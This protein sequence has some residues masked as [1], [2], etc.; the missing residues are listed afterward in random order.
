[1]TKINSAG[2]RLAIVLAFALA[3]ACKGSD[4][5]Q[6][7]AGTNGQDGAAGAPGQN[8]TD[9]TSGTNGT[10]GTNAVNGAVTTGMVIA[11]TGATVNADNTVAVTFTVKDDQGFPVDLKGRYSLNTTIS[12]RFA[13]GYVTKDAAGNVLPYTV[14][15]KSSGSPTALTA[16][17]VGAAATAAGQI[18]ENGTGAGS[19]TYTFP[20]SAAITTPTASHTLWIQASRQTNVDVTTDP[21]TFKAV[22]ASYDWIPT[23]AEGATIVKRELVLTSNCSKCHDEFKPY[24]TAAGGFHSAGRI[25]GPYC[26]VCH[27]PARTSNPA[28]DSAVFV[29][30]IHDVEH[31][32]TVTTGT[33]TVGYQGSTRCTTSAPCV[34]TATDP[35]KPTAFDAITHVTYPQ[36]IRNCDACHKGAAQAAQITARPTRA[37]CGSCHDYVQWTGSAT[38]CNSPPLKDADGQY[39]PC[40]HFSGA[41]ADDTAC[42]GCHSPGNS[43]W[44]KQVAGHTPVAEPDAANVF[45]PK[46]SGTATAGYQG[47]TLTTCTAGAVCACSVAAPCYDPARYSLLS[48]NQKSGSILVGG[49]ACGTGH[50]PSPYTPCTCTAGNPCIGAGS[51][52]TNAASLSAA[53]VVPA[54]ASKVTYVVKTDASSKPAGVSLN[55]ARNPVITFKIQLDGANA[56]FNK[57]GSGKTELIDNFVG[58]PSVYFAFAVAQDATLRDSTALPADFNASVSGYVKGIWATAVTTGSATAGVQN[59]AGGAAVAC[60]AGAPCTCTVDAPCYAAGKDYLLGPDADGFYTVVLASQVL[61]STAKAVML[62][63]GVGYTYGLSSTMPL[64]QINVPGYDYT[65]ATK[66]GGL[67]VSAPNVWQTASSGALVTTGTS[68]TG[69]QGATACTSAAP[70]VCSAGTPC[71]VAFTARRPIVETA[72]CNACHVQLGVAPSFHAGQRNDGPTC[73]FC[74]TPNRTSS[75]WSANA[76]D[77]VHAVH[78]GEQ[79]DVEYRWH[80][81]SETEGYWHITFPGRLNH[82]EACHVPG[83]YNYASSVAAVPNMLWSTVA[84]GKYNGEDPAAARS[85]PKASDGSVVWIQTKSDANFTDDTLDYGFGFATGA[86]RVSDG[87]TITAGTQA[88]V[89]AAGNSSNVT[90]TAGAPC[91][92]TPEQVCTVKTCSLAAPCEADPATLV[93]SPITAACAACHDSAPAMA[94]MKANGATWYQ[95]RSAAVNNVEQCLL[96]HGPQP[97]AIAPIAGAHK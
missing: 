35:C 85:F 1:M 2:T 97:G 75:G 69:T 57:Y 48:T 87:R 24:R 17:A 66:Q 93:V 26:N 46:T 7:P 91:V 77:F 21:T 18:A 27:N 92:C 19:Y 67:V 44:A 58:S 3:A 29:H 45:V 22:N 12:P 71:N 84:T 4:G 6:G 94:H 90:C 11:V 88:I 81:V 63:G 56:T 15:T 95:P 55:A 39:V 89:D 80:S 65:A 73:A 64:T 40:L 61:P 10:N 53:G 72:R 86:V 76:K 36:D 13:L 8:G 52:N 9:G 74:H 31:L 54:G 96:C 62:T 37:A 47:G 82:C 28:A 78:A 41:Q 25:E 38:A 33:S 59:G 49:T 83:S 51:N 5:A 42:Y 14:L 70:C 23:P 79:R 16:P 34:C 20:A 60:S 50:Q 32:Q 30:R 43:A 68:T